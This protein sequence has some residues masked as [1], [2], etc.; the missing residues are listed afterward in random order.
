MISI[1]DELGWQTDDLSPLV[2]KMIDQANA[3]G[4]DDN[5]TCVVARVDR[6]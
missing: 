3:N 1:I 2:N 4:G 5:V 6:S